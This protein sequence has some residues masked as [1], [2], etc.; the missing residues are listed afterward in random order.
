M[1][2]EVDLT[3]VEAFHGA[4]RLLE[5]DGHRIQASIPPGVRTGSR[6]RLAGQGEPGR[7]NGP[8]GDVY[9]IIRL[10]PNLTFEREGD[11]LHMEIAVDFFTAI[12]GG[13]IRPHPGKTAYL[14]DSSADQRRAKFPFKRKRHAPPGKYSSIWGFVC[15]G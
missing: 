11:N 12:L 6:V 14:E 3:L 4:D 1:D 10:L 8:A 9:L 15:Q 2:Y 13:E 5:I 7:N